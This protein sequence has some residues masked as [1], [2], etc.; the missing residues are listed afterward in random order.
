M[1]WEL[2]E[3]QGPTFL[4]FVRNVPV[5]PQF[6]GQK[7]LPSVDTFDLAFEYILGANQRPV[8]AHVMGWDSEA[9]IAGRPGLGEKKSGELPPIKRKARISEKELIRF[10]SPRAG[11]PDVQTAIDSVYNLTGG[12]LDSVQARIEWL[13]MQALSEDKIVYDEDGVIFGFDYG[14]EDT[15]QINLVTQA[16]GAGT[17]V[18]SSVSTVW[19][20]TA[21][22]N[23]VMDLQF[24]CNRVQ[25]ATGLRPREIVFSNKTLGLLLTNDNIRDMIRGTTAPTAI[26]TEQ[27]L[28]TLW[29]LYNLPAWTIYDVMVAKENADGTQSDVRTMAENKAFLIPG[30][31]GP[32]LPGFGGVGATLFGPTAESRP[33]MGTRVASRAPGTFA[34]VYGVEEPPSEWVKAV[35]VAFP[36]LPGANLIAQMT[37]YA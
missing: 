24:L 17:S 1:L 18:A 20:D 37:L 15:F 21:N 14:F 7:W 36:S 34:N 27:E 31:T 9:P 28:R 22:S 29:Q 8:M 6:A 3:F 2:D 12:L 13:R 33:L 35:A 32:I 25:N 5:D 11:T 19:S 16:D 26:L 23:P 10:M 4:G 30:T